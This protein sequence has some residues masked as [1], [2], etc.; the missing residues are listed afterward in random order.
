MELYFR[1][2]DYFQR[3]MKLAEAKPGPVHSGAA[4]FAMLLK[5]IPQAVLENLL[6]HMEKAFPT[7]TQAEC[8]ALTQ[9][10]SIPGK[11]NADDESFYR[12]RSIALECLRAGQLLG[13]SVIDCAITPALVGHCL[14]VGEACRVLA[15]VLG[16][17]ADRAMAIG[18]L[19][20]YGRR[21]D[22]TLGHVLRG[23]ELLSDAGWMQESLGC[24]THSFLGGG[25]CA[26]NEMAEKGFYV[27]EA[28]NPCW[29][30]DA[31][32]DHITEFLSVYSYTDY[33]RIL[34][35]A[36]LMA[37]SYGIVSPAERIKDIA[38]RRTI[39]PVNRGYFLA[40]LTNCLREYTAGMDGAE[41]TQP[42]LY[43]AAGISLKEIED[44]FQAASDLFWEAYCRVSG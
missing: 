9:G 3:A 4:A 11:A 27:D 43:A 32:R 34:N 8:Y 16:L 5:G 33:D 18:T 28:G 42:K 1:T 12:I 39:D 21:A 14:F 35:L 37:T 2:E 13:T 29:E 41:N 36:D 23:F 30:P 44:A 25:R 10:Q 26:S 17:D 15:G 38:T 20:D 6:R 22:G 31:V 40:S 19:H 24:L 7:L